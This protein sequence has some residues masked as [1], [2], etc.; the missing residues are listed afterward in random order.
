MQRAEQIAK[1]NKSKQ[2]KN[3]RRMINVHE[4]QIRKGLEA[5]I[6]RNGGQMKNE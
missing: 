3:M 2:R 4:S 5:G 6:R 1:L